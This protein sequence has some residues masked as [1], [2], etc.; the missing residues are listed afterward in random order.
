MAWSR[1][2]DARITKCPADFATLFAGVARNCNYVSDG[3][4]FVTPGARSE[5]PPRLRQQQPLE[6]LWRRP[7][8]D[9]PRSWDTTHEV[10]RS[11]SR[12]ASTRAS[13]IMVGW[14]AQV[15]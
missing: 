11:W 7:R 3:A 6:G 8:S 12:M 4:A 10:A 13:I 14:P 1:A 5:A 2:S 9:S 15:R